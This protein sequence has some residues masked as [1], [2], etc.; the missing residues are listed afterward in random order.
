MG[1]SEA[2][3]PTVESTAPVMFALHCPYHRSTE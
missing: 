1:L 3:I 2:A